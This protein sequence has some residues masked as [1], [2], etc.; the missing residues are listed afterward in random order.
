MCLRDSTWSLKMIRRMVRKTI[1]E[2]IWECVAI[3]NGVVVIVIIASI[4]TRRVLISVASFK[5]IV[6]ND[7]NAG[8]MSHFM[9]DF[10]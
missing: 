10:I 3:F 6:V 9:S 2:T 7:S 1:K 5:D 4:D 8:K